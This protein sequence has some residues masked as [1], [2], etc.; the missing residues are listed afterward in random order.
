LAQK[1]A[2]ELP[3]LN[4]TLTPPAPAQRTLELDELWSFVHD[5]KNQ[6][7]IW[8]ALCAMTKQ[9]VAFVAGDRGTQTCRA[10]W[11]EIPWRYK[12]A[13]CYSDFWERPKP[14]RCCFGAKKAYSNVVPSDQHEAV[15]KESGKTNHVERWNNTLRQRLGQ[16]VRKTLSFSKCWEL[17]VARLRL[18]VHRYNLEIA[19]NILN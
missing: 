12:R 17:H 1:K 4:T 5:K 14:V 7:W 15:G 3:A 6:C 13:K 10:L 19:E 11:R 18:F 16:F 8:I 2:D 9:M